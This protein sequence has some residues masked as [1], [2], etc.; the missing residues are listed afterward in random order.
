MSRPRGSCG[1]WAACT[2]RHHRQGR[3]PT[4]DSCQL[5]WAFEF[6]QRQGCWPRLCSR[7]AHKSQLQGPW[8]TAAGFNGGPLE[9]RQW[10][11]SGTLLCFA[12]ANAGIQ[13]SC[14][15]TVVALACVASPHHQPCCQNQRHS[16]CEL[17]F[18]TQRA[19]IKQRENDERGAKRSAEPGG[20]RRLQLRLCHFSFV[21]AAINACAATMIST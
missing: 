5:A 8:L 3:G 9:W 15:A 12:A 21:A 7:G 11:A 19:A 10:W 16:C 2:Q 13:V 14:C 18:G 20:K 6:D 4:A 17:Q 1:S